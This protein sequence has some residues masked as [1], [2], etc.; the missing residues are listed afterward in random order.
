MPTGSSPAALRHWRGAGQRRLMGPGVSRVPRRR[1]RGLATQV[2]EFTGVEGGWIVALIGLGLLGGFIYTR[3]Y[4]YLIPGGIMTGLGLGI[5]ASEALA[6]PNEEAS[7]G[8]V[9]LGLGLGFLSIWAISALANVKEH[10]WWPFVPGGILTVVGAALLIGG[11]AVDLLDYWGIAV[12]AIGLIVLWRG[13]TDTH[14]R[15]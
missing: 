2:L 9:V 14:A 12:I 15:T 7:G 8:A 1:L 10:H 3:Q 11:Q 4:G 5:V 6:F 13:W